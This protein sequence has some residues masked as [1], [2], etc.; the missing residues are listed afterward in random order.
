M[1]ATTLM[2]LVLV[3]SVVEARL[4]TSN[5]MIAARHRRQAIEAAAAATTPASPTIGSSP[6]FGS[7]AAGQPLTGAP[8]ADKVIITITQ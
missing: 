2:I 7:F 5:P 4:Y 3:E 6:T 1:S 8:L